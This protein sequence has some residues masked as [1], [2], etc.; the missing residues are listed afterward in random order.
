M[1]KITNKLQD[2]EMIVTK[3]AYENF[4]KS[5]GYTIVGKKEDIE[6]SP[7]SSEPIIKSENKEKSVKSLESKKEESKRK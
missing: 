4:Y 3:G 7:V 2:K 6:P 1:L 5:L